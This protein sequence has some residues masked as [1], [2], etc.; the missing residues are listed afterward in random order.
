MQEIRFNAKKLNKE[1]MHE[2]WVS[3]VKFDLKEPMVKTRKDN[4]PIE[5]DGWRLMKVGF[6]KQKGEKG[7]EMP[8][9]G[10]VVEFQKVEEKP[11]E[12]VKY[13]EDDINPD[14]IPF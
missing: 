8:I 14:D 2:G 7:E 6:V 5:G 9:I 10:D 4:T 12:D 13:P 11:K 1:K 3:L